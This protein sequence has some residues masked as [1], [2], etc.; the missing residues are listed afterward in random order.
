MILAL[1]IKE[2]QYLSHVSW[3]LHIQFR[4]LAEL[5]E[6]RLVIPRRVLALFFWSPIE[7]TQPSLN[8][9]T[10]TAGTPKGS[11]NTCASLTLRKVYVQL[12]IA[13]LW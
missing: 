4:A 1:I 12:N 9:V 11:G 8:V 7:V 5:A 10:Y 6:C 13:F 3:E 2:V